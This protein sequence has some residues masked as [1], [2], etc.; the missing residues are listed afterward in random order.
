[1]PTAEEAAGRSARGRASEGTMRARARPAAR[2]GP[3]RPGPH[4]GAVVL[5]QLSGR[6]GEGVRSPERRLSSVTSSVTRPD[7]ACF[8][9]SESYARVITSPMHPPSRLP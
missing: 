7:S 9:R 5:R 2:S 8:R 1:M 3:P 6:L 4:D